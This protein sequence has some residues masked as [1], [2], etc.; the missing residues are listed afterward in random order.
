MLALNPDEFVHQWLY[1][2]ALWFNGH[3]EEAIAFL[4][5][6]GPS[7]RAFLGY[8]YAVIGRRRDAEQIAAE[9]DVAAVRRQ[10]FVYAGLGDRARVLDAFRKLAAMH[11]DIVDAYPVFPEFALLRDDPGMK[12]FRLSRNLPWPPEARLVEK[13]R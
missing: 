4:E 10:A 9:E 5:Q 12:E 2:R 1:G 7:A 11:D 3:R 6:K 8:A 13:D